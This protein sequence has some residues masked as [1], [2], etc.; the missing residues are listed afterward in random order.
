[1]CDAVVGISVLSLVNLENN[2]IV[3]Q[4][5]AEGTGFLISE[6]HIVTVAHLVLLPL[7]LHRIPPPTVSPNFSKNE[8]I[9]ASINNVNGCGKAYTYNLRLIGVDATSDLAVLEIEETRCEP[10]SPK[11][12]SCHPILK[13]G[14]SRKLGHCDI[15][16]TY[17]S[18]ANG[19]F[20]NCVVGSV[21]NPRY[22][23]EGG[24][25]TPELLS[26]NLLVGE[27][28]GGAP[29]L[30]DCC[31]VVGVLIGTVPDIGNTIATSQHAAQRIIR[32]ILCPNSSKAGIEIIKDEFGDFIRLVRSGLGLITV[33][34][35]AFGTRLQFP[36]LTIRQDNNLVCWS[37]LIGLVVLDVLIGSP[38]TGTLNIGDIIT[39]VKVSGTRKSCTKVHQSKNTSCTSIEH[40]CLEN[41]SNCFAIGKYPGQVSIGTALLEIPPGSV[42]EIVYRK[43]SENFDT[44]HTTSI[45]TIGIPI[46]LDHFVFFGKL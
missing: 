7:G 42:I 4:S 44:C 28:A 8:I 15:I 5:R 39:H 12:T 22:V 24:S 9:V 10:C 29:I 14:K 11:L 43:K 19:T 45:S 40:K 20:A 3:F 35:D 6:K 2:P 23:F 25:S 18:E 17:I 41:F 46:D 32:M 30:N 1:M 31:E 37:E 13:W 36:S 21:R 34:N 33:Y 38:L 26:L 27:G 16:K